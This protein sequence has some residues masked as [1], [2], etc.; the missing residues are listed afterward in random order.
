MTCA[1]CEKAALIDKFSIGWITLK[2]KGDYYPVHAHA[3]PH[4]LLVTHGAVRVISNG[5]P[6]RALPM[7]IVYVPA[8][9]HHELVADEPMSCFVCIQGLHGVD[10]PEELI[11]ECIVPGGT[12]DWN[13]IVPLLA[14]DARRASFTKEPE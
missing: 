12:P 9:V 8:E 14:A 1:T 4:A 3:R 2:N 5:V 10:A 13:R 6:T 11:G 7:D